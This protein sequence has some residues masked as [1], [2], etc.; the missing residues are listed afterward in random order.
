MMINGGSIKFSDRLFTVGIP[1]LNQTLARRMIEE[2]KIYRLLKG[3]RNK[4]PADI[5]LLQEILVRFSNM[6]VDFPQ[7]TEV[8]MNPLV[9]DQS[10]AHVLDA[11]IVIDPQMV[12]RETRPHE[13]LVISPYPKKYETLWRLADGRD[14]LL[15]PIKPEDEPMWLEM[16]QNFSESSI[17]Y[18]FFQMIKDTPHE[19]RIG[20]CNI[21]Y[22]REMAIIAE[23]NDDGKRRIL[24]VVRAILDNDRKNAE[25]AIIVADP[26]QGLGL[27]SKMMDFMIEI[28]KDMGVGVLHASILS[29]NRPA[30]ELMRKMGFTVENEDGSTVSAVLDLPA[31]GSAD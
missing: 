2:T 6:L 8:D 9:I 3:F 25:V 20:Y 29:Q 7:I 27:G 15:R 12:F 21:D 24:G 10:S 16:F 28:C 11:R 4:P 30:I 5:K 19:V 1:P 13:H 18:R 17:R 26:W 22:E 14:V 23:M 31:E